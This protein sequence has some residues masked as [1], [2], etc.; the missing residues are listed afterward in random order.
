M[1]LANHLPIVPRFFSDLAADPAL[2]SFLQCAPPAQ[3]VEPAVVF[4]GVLLLGVSWRVDAILVHRGLNR[5]PHRAVDAIAGLPLH[6]LKLV[7]EFAIDVVFVRLRYSG[8]FGAFPFCEFLFQMVSHKLHRGVVGLDNL[9][10]EPC[11]HLQMI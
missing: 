5:F 2:P 4:H 11:G 1:V 7:L 6:E 3:I 9:G 8:C 10:L